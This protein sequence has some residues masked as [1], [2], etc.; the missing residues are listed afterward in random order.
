MASVSQLISGLERIGKQITAEEDAIPD[1]ELEEAEAAKKEI[2]RQISI[3]KREIKQR[4][5]RIKALER[6]YDELEREIKKLD[7]EFRGL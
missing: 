5:S 4:E 6:E 2:E 7:P 1:A 3:Y